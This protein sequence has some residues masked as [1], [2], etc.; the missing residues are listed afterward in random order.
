M[1]IVAMLQE[2]LQIWV[3]GLQNITSGRAFI[4][5][6]TLKTHQ[7]LCKAFFYIIINY[8]ILINNFGGNYSYFCFKEEETKTQKG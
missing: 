2:N 6:S 7:A 4:M 5:N 8:L 1:T 3:S